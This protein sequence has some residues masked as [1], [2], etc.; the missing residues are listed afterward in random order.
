M[1]ERISN[2]SVVEQFTIRFLDL[3][4]HC[5]YIIPCHLYSQNLVLIYTTHQLVF[6]PYISYSNFFSRSELVRLQSL[7][8]LSVQNINL[9]AHQLI[10]WLWSLSSPSL[11]SC[12]NFNFARYS[13]SIKGIHTKL[14]ILADH[15]KLQLQDKGHN[16]ESYSFGVMPLF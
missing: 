9:L 11:L 4:Y 14:G 8:V 5:K 16:S 7:L 6:S 15:D 3:A 12:K 2:I 10:Y 13:K 1:H